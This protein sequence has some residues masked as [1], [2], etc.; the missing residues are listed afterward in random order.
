MTGHILRISLPLSILKTSG[1]RVM[2][3]VFFTAFTACLLPQMAAAQGGTG[4]L[5]QQPR[6]SVGPRFGF[7]MPAVNSELFD[8]S[9]RQFTLDKGDFRSPYLG[10]ELAVRVADRLDFVTD[11]GWSRSTTDSEYRDWEDLDDLPIEQET[12]FE[13]KSLTFGA[14]YYLGPRGRAVGQFAWIPSRVVPFV[15]AG[16]GIMWHDFNQ[17]GDFVDFDTLDI[18]RDSLRSSGASPIADVRGGVDISL[19]RRVFFTGEARYN[20]GSGE[21]GPD[22]VGFDG[23]DLSGF[24][25]VVGVSFRL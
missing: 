9:R 1:A 22:F 24:R 7:S 5:F 23:I 6:V 17:V 11:F 3:T 2:R 13:R 19:G 25:L 15:G 4:F 8:F 20:F 16:A 21:T 18:F 12:T 14:R 10:G